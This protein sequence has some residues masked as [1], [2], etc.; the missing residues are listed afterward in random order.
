MSSLPT[1]AAF[2][3]RFQSGVYLLIGGASIVQELLPL[4]PKQARITIVDGP[5]EFP[6][7]LVIERDHD[8]VSCIVGD[9][10]SALV[11]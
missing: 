4:F 6:A 2:V 8:T 10:T 7:D 9:G 5:D 11:L 3:G 1:I